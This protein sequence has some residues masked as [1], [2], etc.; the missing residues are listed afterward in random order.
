MSDE[1]KF[2]IAFMIFV[3]LMLSLAVVSQAIQRGCV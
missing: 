3:L 2:L 1:V